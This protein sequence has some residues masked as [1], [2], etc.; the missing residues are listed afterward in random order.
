ML[1]EIISEGNMFDVRLRATAK[2][3]TSIENVKAN[4]DGKAIEEKKEEKWI[5]PKCAPIDYFV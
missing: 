3:C 1:R 2:E 5:A 4:N